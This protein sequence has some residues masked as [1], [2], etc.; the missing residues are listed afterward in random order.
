IATK[1]HYIGQSKAEVDTTPF[2]P[3]II[4]AVKSVARDI[5]TFRVADIKTTDMHFGVSSSHLST[6]RFR[7][8]K[9]PK[10]PKAERRSMFDVVYEQLKNRVDM[11]LSGGTWYG[12][13]HTQNQLWYMSLPLIKKWVDEGRLKKPKN[14]EN[15]LKQISE[16]C[17]EYGV[18]REKVGVMAGAYASMFYNGKWSAVNFAEINLLA[19][20]G[21]AMIFIEKQDVVQTLG[22]YAS[23]HGVALINTKGH[24]SDYAKDLSELAQKSGA[25]IG[26]LTDY[27]IPGLHIASKLKGAVW[28]GIDK[29]MLDHFGIDLNNTD[30][31]IPYD[32]AKGIGDKVIERDIESDERFR[33]PI[34]DIDWLKQHK[35]QGGQFKEPGNK[36]EIDAVLAKAGS[37]RFWEY[38]KKKMEQEYGTFDYNRVINVSGC[39]PLF[40]GAENFVIPPIVNTLKSYGHH[41]YGELTSEREQEIEQELE[42]HKGLTA[43]SE[44]ENEIRSELREIVVEDEECKDIKAILYEVGKSV[45]PRIREELLLKIKRLDEDKS[46]GLMAKL[47]DMTGGS[48]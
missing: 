7:S 28:L 10:P 15:F 35:R 8:W 25:K 47:L 37:E 40:G 4:Q 12:E 23:R 44:K 24:L 39:S 13:L 33:H 11:V 5:P 21:V 6:T 16:V 36:V 26:I 2:I 27:D 30:Y 41:R 31:V 22:P 46:Y 38:L 32:P 48:L 14:R 20:M 34:T 1:L 19:T 18:E 17:D 43:V 45:G 9:E 3:A 29:P 42:E